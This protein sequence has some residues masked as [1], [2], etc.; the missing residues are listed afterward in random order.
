MVLVWASMSITTPPSGSG[1][2]SM[3]LLVLHAIMAAAVIDNRN[4]FF[5]TV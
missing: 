3:S 5:I 1:S 4:S 2:G